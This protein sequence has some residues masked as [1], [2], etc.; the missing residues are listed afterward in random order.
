MI[1]SV[2]NQ[3]GGVG[4]TTISI[5]LAAA[6]AAIGRRVLLIDADPQASSLAWSAARTGVPPFAV[7]GVPVPT[8][9]RDVSALACDYDLVVIDA[10]P[11]VSELGR[12]AILA[13]EHGVGPGDA[14]AARC[15]G[16][17]RGRSADSRSPTV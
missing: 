16:L 13:A 11:R 5:N 10:A 3:K 9:H 8:L 7:V 1:I 12:A 6:A 14:V 15:L 2:A 17:K 4:K